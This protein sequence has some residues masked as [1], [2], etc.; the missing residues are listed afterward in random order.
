MA[1]LL[2][3]YAANSPFCSYSCKKIDLGSK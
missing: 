2:S 1:R 3:K